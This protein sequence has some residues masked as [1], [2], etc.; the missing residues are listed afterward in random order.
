MEETATSSRL[1]SDEVMADVASNVDTMMENIFK[2]KQGSDGLSDLL[3]QESS[4]IGDAKNARSVDAQEVALSNLSNIHSTLVSKIATL[5]PL[6]RPCWESHKKL[7][8]ALD[9]FARELSQLS[10]TI[11]ETESKLK[12][13]A[14]SKD[15]AKEKERED[16][17]ETTRKKKESKR[18][19]RRD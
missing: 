15:S 9:D 4:S 5:R 14:K 10:D 3:M 13:K 7:I 18:D 19:K 6:M 2:I 16:E 17:K 12:K 1:L 8:G 11:E